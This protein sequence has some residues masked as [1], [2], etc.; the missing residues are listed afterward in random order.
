MTQRR[1]VRC[2][3]TLDES[4]LTTLPGDEDESRSVIYLRRFAAIAFSLRDQLPH[5]WLSWVAGSHSLLGGMNATTAISVGRLS[6]P[7]G[8]IDGTPVHRTSLGPSAHRRDGNARAGSRPS[9]RDRTATA[10]R[11]GWRGIPSL[12]AMERFQGRRGRGLS[13]RASI[14]GLVEDTTRDTSN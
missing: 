10:F 7:C 9:R 14:R 13:C 2:Q 4:M 1:D 6:R 12:A 8:C 11:S 5:A 3:S